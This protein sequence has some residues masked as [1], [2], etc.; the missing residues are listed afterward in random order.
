MAASISLVSGV[1][2]SSS[3][4]H[5]IFCFF[6]NS[7][8]MANIIHRVANLSIPLYNV[9]AT[10]KLD[11]MKFAD[12]LESKFLAWQQ[13]EGTRKTLA[14]FAD[15]LGASRSILSLWL[16]GKRKPGPDNI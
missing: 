14:E 16:S 13:R 15:Y 7:C 10:I 11:I 2:K 1:G 8:F 3:L 9:S 12:Y 4:T 5:C 6:V